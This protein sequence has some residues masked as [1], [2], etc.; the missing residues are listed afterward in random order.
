M[1]WTDRVR[2]ELDVKTIL[3]IQQNMNIINFRRCMVCYIGSSGLPKIHETDTIVN[4]EDEAQVVCIVTVKCI[5]VVN[6][7]YLCFMWLVTCSN[8]QPCST[9]NYQ[10]CSNFYNLWSG[11][12]KLQATPLIC[13]ASML[14]VLV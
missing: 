11:L 8:F 12:D 13:M 2:A 1:E 5:S 4:H 6:H 9:C 10:P 7:H 14:Q 3:N